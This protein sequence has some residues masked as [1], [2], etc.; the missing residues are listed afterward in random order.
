MKRLHSKTSSLLKN[1]KEYRV[2]LEMLDHTNLVLK[3][4]N[5][6]EISLIDYILELGIYYKSFERLLQMEKELNKSHAE[7]MKYI[8]YPA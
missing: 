8:K 7:L 6:G 5:S 4:L 3:A 2:E 1:V